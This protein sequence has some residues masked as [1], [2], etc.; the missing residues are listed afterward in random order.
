M[1]SLSRPQRL[2][3]ATAVT[4]DDGTVLPL[5]AHRPPTARSPASE[6]KGFTGASTD[7]G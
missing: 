2:T 1:P 5:H 4:G 3:V 7:C 6:R